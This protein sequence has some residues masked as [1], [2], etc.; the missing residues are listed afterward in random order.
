[1]EAEHQMKR[2]V[3]FLFIFAWILSGCTSNSHHTDATQPK[4]QPSVQTGDIQVQILVPKQ[5]SA[6]TSTSL[7][8]RVQHGQDAVQDADEVEFEVWKKNQKK[9]SE[10]V[11]AQH[12][13]NGIYTAQKTFQEEGIYYIQAHV[14]ARGMHKMPIHELVVGEKTNEKSSSE[15]EPTE[16][17]HHHHH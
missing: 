5:I 13:K 10:K 3:S 15:E 14:T 7:Q 11:K 4:Q 1:M 6:N 9:S 12:E 2:I 17:N 16:E 8:V